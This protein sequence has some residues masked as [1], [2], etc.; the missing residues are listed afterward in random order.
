MMENYFFSD[1]FNYLAKKQLYTFNVLAE[2]L[3]IAWK[4]F[5]SFTDFVTGSQRLKISLV[6]LSIQAY[7]RNY[8]KLKIT[9]IALKHYGQVWF[10]LCCN[11]IVTTSIYKVRFSS[12]NIRNLQ[13]KCV[14][15]SILQS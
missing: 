9:I 4:Q 10:K 15:E 11:P 14:K 1:K 5:V 13:R 2:W 3:K 6:S 12:Y 8:M 7:L